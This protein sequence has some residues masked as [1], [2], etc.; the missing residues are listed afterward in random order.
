MEYVKKALSERK[1][2]T[3]NLDQSPVLFDHHGRHVP[4]LLASTTAMFGLLR[5]RPLT[6]KD[7]TEGRATRDQL[8]F[9]ASAHL[10]ISIQPFIFPARF[11]E[12]MGSQLL[13]PTTLLGEGVNG[14]NSKG[15][16]FYCF[17]F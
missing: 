3:A 12:G 15:P 9:Q 4:V 17:Q 2:I 11:T 16:L 8:E 14:T 10:M 13:M 1:E 7:L 6:W 5:G